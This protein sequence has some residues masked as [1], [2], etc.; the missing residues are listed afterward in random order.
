[1][2]SFHL[3]DSKCVDLD[4]VHKFVFILWF[5]DVSFIMDQGLEMRMSK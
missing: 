1:V 3:N 2:F 5:C 4:I